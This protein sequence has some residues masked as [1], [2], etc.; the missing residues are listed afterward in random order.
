MIDLKKLHKQYGKDIE[1]IDTLYI[2]SKLDEEYWKI[3]SNELYSRR[4]ALVEE[5][6]LQGIPVH[7]LSAVEVRG[8]RKAL[9][10]LLR[11]ERMKQ[12][13]KKIKKA[14]L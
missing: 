6:I 10:L 2:N 9:D 11:N 4:M 13:I 14:A 7:N 3:A 1:F 5:M 8:A 12:L